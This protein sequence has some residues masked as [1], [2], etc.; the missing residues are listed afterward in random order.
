M[1]MKINRNYFSPESYD[2]YMTIINSKIDEDAWEHNSYCLST[3]RIIQPQGMSKYLLRLSLK[4]RDV[5]FSHETRSHNG[6]R[7]NRAP[8]FIRPSVIW[9][10]LSS[11]KLIAF[12]PIGFTIPQFE[13]CMNWIRYTSIHCNRAS[14]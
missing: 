3:G 1:M 10:F 11:L 6:D 4:R 8:L 14:P 9:D 13:F 5:A 12:S 2:I 7:R